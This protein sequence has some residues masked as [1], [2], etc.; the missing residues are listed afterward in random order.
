MCTEGNTRRCSKHAWEKRRTGNTDHIFLALEKPDQADN[1]ENMLDENLGF[2]KKLL[3]VEFFSITD[4][5]G[6]I[7][8]GITVHYEGLIM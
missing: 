4:C 2:M 1:P 7:C 6:E 8:F 3:F 5:M